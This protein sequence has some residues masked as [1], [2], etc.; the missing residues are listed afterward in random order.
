MA[1]V[2]RNQ[3]L[4]PAN[5]S[6]QLGTSNPETLVSI[7]FFFIYFG[8]SFV[9]IITV[10]FSCHFCPIFHI[11]FSIFPLH[12]LPMVAVTFAVLVNVSVSL[13]LLPTLVSAVNGPVV[14]ASL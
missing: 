13:L 2:L 7:T 3:I 4:Q 8:I 9:A 12:L 6:H 14:V 11:A 5:S 1:E 10:L